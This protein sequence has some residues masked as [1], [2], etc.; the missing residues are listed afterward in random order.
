MSSVFAVLIGVCLIAFSGVPAALW[1]ARSKA[2]Q[3]C[4]VSLFAAGSLFGVAGVVLS[5]L[6]GGVPSVIHPWVLPWG[7]FFVSI[8]GLSAF[9][10]LLVFTVPFLGSV[11][12]LGYW[13]QNDHPEN[14]RRL[15][16][17]F[18]LLTASMA[19]VTIAR[20]AVLFLIVWEV[21]ALS[22]WFAASVESEKEEVRKAGWVYL[23]ATHIGTLTLLAMFALWRNATGSFSLDLTGSV[24]AGTAGLIFVLAVIGFGFKAGLMP[25][26]VWLPGAHANAPSHVSAVM[27]GV[28]LKMGVYGIIRMASLFV[29]CEPWW[30][31]M[32]LVVGCVSALFG[33][34]FAMGQRDIKRILAYSSIE[35][36]GI[37]TMGVAVA[38]LGKAYGVPSLVLLGLGGALFHVWNHGLFKSLLF[39]GSGAIIHA[40]G[41]RDI[42]AL[43]GLAKK[44]PVTALLFTVG[45]VAISALPPLNGFAGEWLIYMGMFKTLSVAAGSGMPLAAISAVVLSMVGALAVAVFVRLVSTVFLGSPRSGAADGAHDPRLSMRVPM[46]V[47]ALA[48]VL[49]GVF[50]TVVAPVLDRAARAWVPLRDL[51]FPITTLVPQQWITWMGALL[52]ALLALGALW[53][54]VSVRR[55][56]E[57]AV[58]PTWD[59]G[60]A[61][62]SARVQYTGSSL[63]QQCVKLFSFVL[64]PSRT[65]VQLQKPFAEP[66]R[67]DVTVN[68]TVLDRCVLPFFAWVK[69]VM[70]RFYVFQQGQ[71]YLYVLY[72]VIITAVLFVLGLSGVIA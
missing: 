57:P 39:L 48:C 63:A 31:A 51:G 18:G 68:D 17:F 5:L 29:T 53:Y 41:T 6:Q 4:T 60:Y 69:G 62:P 71:T 27:S 7:Q 37:V 28:M 40:S 21:M 22:A 72:V 56:V 55:R 44:M 30:G 10:L 52:I 36:I 25:L 42:E 19:M 24:T 3:W 46:C 13:K 35:N 32:L 1:R 65:K 15:G 59:C 34:A 12:G 67:F 45:A 66:A 49:F 33:I 54:F 20:D 23:V 9:F 14:G 58:R 43:G 2:G 64:M 16:V 61:Q 47:L 11:Y 26:H 70:P 50:P 38:L 8:D